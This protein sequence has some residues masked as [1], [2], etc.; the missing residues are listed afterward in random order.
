MQALARDF[1]GARLALRGAPPSSRASAL[2]LYLRG[3]DAV[4]GKHRVRLGRALALPA[5][6]VP[7]FIAFVLGARHAVLL[8]DDTWESGGALWFRDL[9]L[10]DPTL[11][12]PFLASGLSYAAL[13][14]VFGAPPAQGAP[15]SAAA[16][17]PGIAGVLA[18][19]GYAQNAK[20]AFQM[21]IL[22][23]APFTFSLPSVR[24]G[25]RSGCGVG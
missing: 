18:R 2:G 16:S 6:Q 24:G 8:G 14:V 12:L 21:L 25:R 11:A 17:R 10:A 20:S 7:V 9:T 15:R 23:A 13:E 19:G 1:A 3:V 5:L 22:V 4:L